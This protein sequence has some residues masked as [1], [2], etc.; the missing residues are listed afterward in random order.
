MHQCDCQQ[1]SPWEVT[2][3]GFLELQTHVGELEFESEPEANEQ[4]VATA[5]AEPCV[6]S[7]ADSM[8]NNAGKAHRQL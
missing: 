1:G 3:P 7:R 6:C 5:P 4:V 8:S 2:Q